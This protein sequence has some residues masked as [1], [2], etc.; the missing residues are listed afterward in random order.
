MTNWG[1]ASVVR[2]GQP[3]AGL[4]VAVA[5]AAHWHLPRHVDNLRTAG[6]TFVAVSAHD[7]AVAAQWADS[8]ECPAV[9]DTAGIVAAR[10]D[11][12][13]AV[14]RVCD[15]AAQATILL[16]AGL[17][18]LAEKPLGLS[19]AEIAPLAALAR[20]RGVWVSVALVQRY[21]P[22]WGILDDLRHQGTLGAL[23]HMH[24]RIINGP[25]QRYAAWGSGWMLD[26]AT[27]GGGGLLNLGIHCMDFFRHL[28]GG[29]A[30]VTGAAISHASHH[31]PVEDF[32]AATLRGPDGLVGSVEA[33]YT[34]P[35]VAAGMTRSG[36]NETR[37]GASQSY[38]VARDSDVTLYTPQG[39]HPMPGSRSGNRY[40]EWIFDSVA[41]FRAGQPPQAT[42]DDCLEAVRLV[43][44]AYQIAGTR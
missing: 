14:G 1:P 3:A 35:D 22:L 13:L 26:R 5:G 12:V 15:M 38:L 39:E 10:P 21:D 16:N 29:E 33:G 36:E 4:R 9:R 40:K 34:Y 27:A 19:S 18:L 42:I 43:E 7:P 30:A 41:R 23:T 28:A 6:A 32:G 25:P 31:L 11:L 44:A 24:M 17:P 2:N 20:Q 8:L 37:I